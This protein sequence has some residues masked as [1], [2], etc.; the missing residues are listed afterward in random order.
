MARATEFGRLL[1][2]ARMTLRGNARKHE[3][4]RLAEQRRIAEAAARAEAQL[5][6]RRTTRDKAVSELIEFVRDLRSKSK[7][8]RID[9]DE[10]MASCKLAIS[11][12]YRNR[13][14][15][16][17]EVVQ[18]SEF[19]IAEHATSTH[20][21]VKLK[22]RKLFK[23]VLALRQFLMN[24]FLCDVARSVALAE[25]ASQAGTSAVSLQ[26]QAPDVSEP[27]PFERHISERITER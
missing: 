5:A 18:R 20:I 26:A 27:Q 21:G 23:S 19:T 7:H 16:T 14:S 13:C 24:D 10:G 2:A 4:A 1:N 11:V 8:I 22:P 3:S 15:N 17:I 9:G 25:A 12:C 6:E